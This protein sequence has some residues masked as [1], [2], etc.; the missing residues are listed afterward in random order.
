MIGHK[1]HRHYIHAGGLSVN[2]YVLDNNVYGIG[3]REYESPEKFIWVNLSV[4]FSVSE[5]CVR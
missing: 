1:Y 4:G 3:V 2:N 5:I